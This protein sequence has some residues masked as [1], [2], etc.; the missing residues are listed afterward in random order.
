MENCSVANLVLHTAADIEEFFEVEEEERRKEE[1][2]SW[3]WDEMMRR[4]EELEAREA[5]GDNDDEEEEEKAQVPDLAAELK[6]KGNSAFAKR[7]F[8]E[9]VVFYSQ[10]IALEPSSHVSSHCLAYMLVPCS[11]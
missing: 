10:A 11:H 9:S 2:T 4:M 8:Q 7:K 3:N 5:S 1:Q 6:A